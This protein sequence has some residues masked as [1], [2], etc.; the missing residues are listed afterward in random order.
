MN[1]IVGGNIIRIKTILISIFIVV[2]TFAVTQF[3]NNHNKMKNNDDELVFYL[4]YYEHE[5]DK[6][7]TQLDAIE[8]EED[9]DKAI[10][11]SDLLTQLNSLSVLVKNTQR[12]LDGI[13][14]TTQDS[15]YWLVSIL[16]GNI[17][18]N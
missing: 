5:L 6:I 16:K 4:T 18:S 2:L 14:F 17:R 9:I 10:F 1:Y 8:H 15:F 12:Y 13:E 3:M 7:I 11:Y